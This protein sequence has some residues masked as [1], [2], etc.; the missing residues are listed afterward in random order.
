[1]FNETK[2]TGDSFQ[3]NFWAHREMATEEL[4][5]H[6]PKRQYTRVLND[7]STVKVEGNAAD[8]KHLV[9]VILPTALDLRQKNHHVRAL[10]Y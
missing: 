7:I 10:P 1:L 6:I 4:E 5:T 9:T 8:E 3:L 2:K